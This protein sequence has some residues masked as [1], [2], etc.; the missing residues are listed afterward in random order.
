MIN[1]EVHTLTEITKRLP[2]V[3]GRNIHPSTLWRWARKGVNGVQLE[4]LRLGGRL[5]TSLEAL[6]RFGKRLAEVGAE[7]RCRP[8]SRRKQARTEGQR[9][10]AVRAAERELDRSGF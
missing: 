5:F 10:R 8:K 1:E 9:E 7:S 4:V 6:E 2:K 3:N